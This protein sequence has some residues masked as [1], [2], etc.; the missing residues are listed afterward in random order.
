MRFFGTDGA[1]V[2]LFGTDR[3][4]R[5]VYSRTVSDARMSLLIGF[6]GV[7]V[8]FVLGCLISGVS[9]MFGGMVDEVLLSIPTIPLWMAL[10]AAIPRHWR[11][12]E[13]YFTI[14]IVLAVVGWAV[15]RAS[16]AASCCRCAKRT[17]SGRPRFAGATD[18][19]TIVQ[20]LLPNFRQLF[21]GARHARH[22]AD[23]PRRDLAQLPGSRHAAAGGQLGVLLKAAQGLAA[24]AQRFWQLIPDI[25]VVLAV[26]MF[27]F[28]GNPTRARPTLRPGVALS[29]SPSGPLR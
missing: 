3:L 24:V 15:W 16:C 28:V 7:F 18:T 20:H 4:G 22:A 9:G 11:V 17:S 14:T 19:S 23:H 10:E 5:D 29:R 27:S 21:C 13:T 26:L 12:T 2:F 25:F 6:G 1:L 8:S